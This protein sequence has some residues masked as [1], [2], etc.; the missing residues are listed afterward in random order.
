MF[1]FRIV[2]II[3][4]FLVL[5]TE[6]FIRVNTNINTIQMLIIIPLY[7]NVYLKIITPFRAKYTKYDKDIPIGIP[8]NNDLIQ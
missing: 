4:L 5:L 1:S 7:G 3:F 2:S 8:I 6:Y